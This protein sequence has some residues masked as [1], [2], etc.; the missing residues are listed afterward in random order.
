[1]RARVRASFRTANTPMEAMS[2][3][4]CRRSNSSTKGAVALAKAP[5]YAA[6]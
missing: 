5:V 3:S 4:N 6:T 1:M 2:H